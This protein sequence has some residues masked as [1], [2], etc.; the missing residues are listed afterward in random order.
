[1]TFDYEFDNIRFNRTTN[2]P[3][4]T[5]IFL[6]TFITYVSVKDA[7]NV[8]SGIAVGLQKKFS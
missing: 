5:N 6:N 3:F 4:T 2:P 8:H 1:M 7:E